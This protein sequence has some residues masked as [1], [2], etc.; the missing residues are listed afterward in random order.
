MR[1]VIVDDEP[2]MIRSLVTFLHNIKR[3]RSCFFCF[4]KV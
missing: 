1:A 3:F 4:L 2:I